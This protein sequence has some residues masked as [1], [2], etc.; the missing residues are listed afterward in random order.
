MA[1]SRPFRRMVVGLAAAA[2]LGS[3]CNGGG[4]ADVSIEYNQV[5]YFASYEAQPGVTST[6]SG[7]GGYILYRINSIENESG[8]TFIVNPARFVATLDGEED[9]SREHAANE[10]ELLG[11]NALETATLEEGDSLDD[12]GCIIMVARVENAEETFG[13]FGG[14]TA[15]VDL[16]YEQPGDDPSIEATREE[17]NT[18]FQILEG[19][20][21]QT[22]Q[23]ACE[24]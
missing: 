5:A 8:G 18:G 12:A 15:K 22:V 21:P 24:G 3:A 9:G 13:N 14:T 6:P 17:G 19:A 1:H 11:D 23:D 10:A 4:D 16:T 20:N 2:L 7:N